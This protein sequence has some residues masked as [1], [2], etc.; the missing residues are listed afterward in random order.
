MIRIDELATKLSNILNRIDTETHLISYDLSDYNFKVLTYGDYLDKI[1]DKATKEN[2]IPVYIATQQGDFE[3]IP[4]LKQVDINFDIYIYFPLDYK[5]QFFL[6]TE[7]LQNVFV[8]KILDY[9]TNSGKAISN[10]SV[11]KIEPIQRLEMKEF[12]DWSAAVFDMPVDMTSKWGV[13]SF[14]LFLTQIANLG[15]ENGFILGNQVNSTLSF[16]YNNITYSEQLV[17]ATDVRNQGADNV[18]QQLTDEYETKNITKN[19]SYVDSFNVYCRDNDFWRKFI[20]LFENG[21]LQNIAFNYSRLYYLTTTHVYSKTCIITSC[22]S[23]N[24]LGEPKIFTIGL[25][26]KEVIE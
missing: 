26:K 15:L 1:S 21:L 12:K 20:E 24:E 8:G 7:F 22:D 16:S 9:G 19:T 11:P 13:M 17:F 2:F 25:S 4:N 23:S 18:A 6:L 14:Q 10:I 3:P 5:N